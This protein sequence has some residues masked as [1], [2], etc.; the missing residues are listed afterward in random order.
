[1]CQSALTAVN[2]DPPSTLRTRVS[3]LGRVRDSGDSTSWQEFY[4]L[5]RR[6][7]FGFARRAGLSDADAEEVTQD[8][9][10]RVAETIHTFDP[11]PAKGKFRNWLLTQT[12][13][14]IADKFA[15]RSPTEKQLPAARP[16]GE[17]RTATIERLPDGEDLDAAWN[18]EWEQHVLAAA[19]ERLA[20]RVPAR[21]YQ[22]FELYVRR[23]EPVLQVSSQLGLNPARIYLIAHRLTRQLKAEVAALRDA[24]G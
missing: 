18:N 6:L 9:F 2:S 8:V 13:W 5:Y 20:R 22:A 1:M 21:H 10:A 19:L 16:A 24:L 4:R 15:A 7:I 14:R 23:G 12:R 3:L 17:P 11:D